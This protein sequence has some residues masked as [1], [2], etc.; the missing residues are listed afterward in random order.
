[1]SSPYSI[2]SRPFAVPGVA[3]GGQRALRAFQP[4]GR[5]VEQRHPRRVR[6][7]AQVPA[8][9]RRLDR[10]LPPGQPVHRRVDVIGGRPGHPEVGAQGGIAPPGQ[11][12]QLRARPDH[13]GDDQ[14]QGQVPGPARRAEQRGQPQFRGQA[15]TAATCPCG[16]DP[17]TVTACPACTSRSPFKVA[18]IAA[19]ASAWQRRKVRQRL[20][21]HLAA[22]PV[23]AAHQH[24][25][26]HPPLAGLRHIGAPVP[27]YVHRAATCR[28]TT[29]LD[30]TYQER[31]E[32]TRIFRGYIRRLHLPAF[33]T[34]GP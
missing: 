6:L 21:P 34:S 5:Q 33:S 7:P 12:G 8:A 3:A 1:M 11:G 9:Q 26:I 10:V 30:G 31:P 13:P 19:T 23:G 20:M 22:V 28:H 4:G 14:R 29:I 2:C 32:T 15:C 27:G 24:R 25:L 18:S 16:S 17:V